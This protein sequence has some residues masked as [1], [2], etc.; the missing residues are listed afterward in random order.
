M[1]ITLML[2]L[3]GN[4]VG[5]NQAVEQNRHGLAKAWAEFGDLDPTGRPNWT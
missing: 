4:A 2:R 1:P 5:L 3:R